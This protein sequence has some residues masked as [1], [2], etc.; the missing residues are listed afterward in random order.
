M[1]REKTW[2]GAWAVHLSLDGYVINP[3]WC[4]THTNAC[5]RCQVKARQVGW[6]LDLKKKK[7][8]KVK[9]GYTL[10]DN[11]LNSTEICFSFL[12]FLLFIPYQKELFIASH[13]VILLSFVTHCFLYFHKHSL[14]MLFSMLN[15]LYETLAAALPFSEFTL[16]KRK[17]GELD[18]WRDW[19]QQFRKVLIT[20]FLFT[21][22]I[23]D[24][25]FFW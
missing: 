1:F 8:K 10:S 24:A 2:I 11:S 5:G 21:F 12:I 15:F 18:P 19:P 4:G 25:S 20:C 3:A 7:K 9:R 23:C 6:E 16:S 13:Y 17:W 14:S 22:D